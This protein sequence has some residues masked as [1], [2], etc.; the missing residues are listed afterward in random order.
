MKK[1]LVI[2]MIV[3]MGIIG[4]SFQIKDIVKE[5]LV[6]ELDVTLKIIDYYDNGSILYGY[7]TPEGLKV[8]FNDTYDLSYFIITQ[9]MI[10]TFEY[11]SEYYSVISKYTGF[12]YDL[13]RNIMDYMRIGANQNPTK[14][15]N[16]ETI[17]QSF[18][19]N[20]VPIAIL[21]NNVDG[22][23]IIFITLND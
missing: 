13:A 10:N 1:L 11:D 8:G 22:N 15:R 21:I 2:S 7:D 16:G 4:M 19:F 23:T 12:S 9:T 17:I 6:N 18:I 14:F 5:R 20:S 3:L